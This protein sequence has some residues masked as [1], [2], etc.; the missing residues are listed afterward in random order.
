MRGSPVAQYRIRRTQRALLYATLLAIAAFAPFFRLGEAPLMDV[1]ESMYAQ[2]ARNMVETGDWVTPRFKGEPAFL[3]PP[4]YYWAA[5]GS[6][7]LLGPSEAA[8]RGVSGCF[9]LLTLLLTFLAGRALVDRDA[10][11]LAALLL[12]LSPGFVLMIRSSTVDMTLTLFMTAVLLG[13]VRTIRREPVDGRLVPDAASFLMIWTG[14]ALATLTKG[15][16]GLLIPAAVLGLHALATGRLRRLWGKWLAPGILLYLAVVLTWYIAC[17][18]LHGYRFI[19][20]NLVLHNLRKFLEPGLYAHAPGGLFLIENLLWMFFPWILLLAAAFASSLGGLLFKRG[21]ATRLPEDGPLLLWLWILVPLIVFSISK[22]KLPTYM[23][24]ALPA[25]AILVASRLDQWIAG[26]GD[27]RGRTERITLALGAGAAVLAAFAVLAGFFPHPS[28]AVRALPLLA[29]LPAIGLSLLGATPGRRKVALAA[30]CAAL[31]CLEAVL[32]G[33]AQPRISAYSP[34]REIGSM[35]HRDLG[36]GEGAFAFR[37]G[38]PGSLLFY[39]QRPVVYMEGY[40]QLYNV[41]HDRPGL[42]LIESSEFDPLP[43][44]WRSRFEP[45]AAR[46]LFHVSKP[47]PEFLLPKTRDRAVSTLMLLRFEKG[48]VGEAADSPAR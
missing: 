14:A 35:I 11:L 48:A 25:C 47:T 24:P 38:T 12:A 9:G 32:I 3:K 46:P 22:Y 40:D 37:T 18:R 45:I 4:L 43:E 20:S 29:I 10:G 16:I 2:I 41:L 15:P 27:T 36:P 21:K 5:A 13:Y 33:Y 28:R 26:K 34:Y 23:D 8:V 31:L 19:E 6:M 42:L 1:D 17:Y 44:T 30:A 7:S 39:A